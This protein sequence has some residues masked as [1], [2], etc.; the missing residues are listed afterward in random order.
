MNRAQFD[1][2]IRTAASVTGE[3]D[4]V[5]IGSQAILELWCPIRRPSKGSRRLLPCQP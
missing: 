1:H 4:I 2:V 5:V 3:E